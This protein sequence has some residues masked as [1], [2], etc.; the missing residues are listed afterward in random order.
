ME[1]ESITAQ[2]S[3]IFAVDI[4]KLGKILRG[5][6]EFI[7]A[8]QL[9]RCGTSIGANVQEAGAA[10]SLKDF[11]SKMSIASK[12]ARE[13]RYW[14]LLLKEIQI[15]DFD[16]TNYLDSINELIRLLTSSVKTAKKRDQ[17]NT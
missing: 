10:Q 17:L 15:V 3:F 8:D 13:T 16:F 4:I 1:K 6:R 7:L 11:I 14:L 9:L 12:E 5:K 2:K